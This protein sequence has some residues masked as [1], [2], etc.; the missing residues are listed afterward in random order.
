[1]VPRN[2]P[3]G[4][5]FCSRQTFQRVNL[6]DHVTKEKFFFVP[7]IFVL[8]VPPA[9]KFHQK[10]SQVVCNNREARNRPAESNG[11]PPLDLGH[12]HVVLKWCMCMLVVDLGI[13]M[14]MI[15]MF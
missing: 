9:L 2:L 15:I 7:L 4:D 10:R 3:K 6:H 12:R 11:T 5:G 13:G 14:I 8:V 1:M